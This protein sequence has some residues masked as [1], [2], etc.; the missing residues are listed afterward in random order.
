LK[1][2]GQAAVTEAFGTIIFVAAQRLQPAPDDTDS[3]S[4]RMRTVAAV[5]TK[6]QANISEV[7]TDHLPITAGFLTAAFLGIGAYEWRLSCGPVEPG[8]DLA[9]CYA[10][11]LLVDFVDTTT[12]H[13]GG[14]AE[15]LRTVLTSDD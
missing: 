7:T 14:F 5:M 1:V 11:W 6:L 4:L 9:W 13:P 2:W 12:E 3:T 8:E 10:A 15:V